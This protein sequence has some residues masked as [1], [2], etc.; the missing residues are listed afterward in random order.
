MSIPTEAKTLYEDLLQQLIDL[1]VLKMQG[2]ES[3]TWDVDRQALE[4]KVSEYYVIKD[5]E[6]SLVTSQG[7][8]P[9]E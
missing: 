6:A 5:Y 2:L 9:P 1:H 4:V 7:G 8:P 3:G